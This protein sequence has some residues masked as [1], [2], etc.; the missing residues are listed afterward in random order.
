MGSIFLALGAVILLTVSCGGTG[1]IKPHR[2]VSVTIDSYSAH[3]F[4]KSTTF[5]NYALIA[6][7]ANPDN[8]RFTWSKGDVVKQD[9]PQDVYIL[10]VPVDGQVSM[11]LTATSLDGSSIGSAQKSFTCPDRSPTP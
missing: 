11:R 10:T 7:I 4:I 2:L 5:C 8:Y 6:K 9:G 1:G 3:G